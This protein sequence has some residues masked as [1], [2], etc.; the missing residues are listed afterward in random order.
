MTKKKPKAVMVDGI[1]IKPIT[2]AEHRRLD[3]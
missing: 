3:R 2:S 1:P